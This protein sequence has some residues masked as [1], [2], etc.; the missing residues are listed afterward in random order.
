MSASSPDSG[1]R[2]NLDR[3]TWISYSQLALFAFFIYGFGATQALLRDEQGTSRTV[4]SL[5][6]AVFAL[7]NIAAGLLAPRLIA[8]WGRGRVI[9]YAIVV[10]CIGLLVYTAPFGLAAS[11]LGTAIVST[12]GVAMIVTTNAFILDYQGSAGPAAL[13][14]ANALA[15]FFGFIVPLVIGATTALAIGWRAGLWALVVALLIS[16]VLRNRNDSSPEVVRA[17]FP[18]RTHPVRADKVQMP[19]PFWWSLAVVGLLL[20]TEFTITLWSADLL[21]ERAGLGAAAAAATL[22]AVTGGMFLGRAYGSRLAQTWS[23]DRMLIASILIALAG[24]TLAWLSTNTWVIVLALFVVGLG[25]SIQWPIGVSRAVASS[26]GLIDKASGLSSVA[27]GASG[28]VAPFVLG[29]LS[30][31]IGVHAAFLIVPVMLATAL[32]LVIAKPVKSRDPIVG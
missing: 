29:A 13:T 31:S 23:V 24:F 12:G 7:A 21:R 16:E 15:A 11:L 18:A 5:H 20:A 22:A 32:V 30:D 9:R 8:R 4:A 28:G 26:G 3:I 10:M 2:P 25:L 1:R 19:R 27:A 14:Q 17:D 6:A